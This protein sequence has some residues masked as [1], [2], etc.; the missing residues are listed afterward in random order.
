MTTLNYKHY[1]LCL[2]SKLSKERVALLAK[3]EYNLDYMNM[4]ANYLEAV[5][6]A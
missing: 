2:S 3:K 1:G 6:L 5:P 4:T